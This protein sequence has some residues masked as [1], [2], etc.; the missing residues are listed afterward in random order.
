MKKILFA[1]LMLLTFTCMAHADD[2]DKNVSTFAELISH[3]ENNQDVTLTC[4]ITADNDAFKTYCNGYDKLVYSGIFD[5]QGHKLTGLS[6]SEKHK[7][8]IALFRAAKGATFKDFLMIDANIC[9]YD[10]V[11]VFCVDAESCTLDGI[12]VRGRIEANSNVGGV[13]SV[14]KNSTFTNCRFDYESSETVKEAL[15]G[16]Y[17]IGGI[18]GYSDNCTF[19][20]CKNH[21]AVNGN[22][23]VG[24]ICGYAL[25]SIITACL[26]SAYISSDGQNAGGICGLA[27][28]S[29]FLDCECTSSGHIY[30]DGTLYN[31]Y[32][33]GIVGSLNEDDKDRSEYSR[34]EGC[35]NRGYVESNGSGY[36]GGITGYTFSTNITRCCN[37]GD[38][39]FVGSF[40]YP[41]GGIVGKAKKTNISECYNQGIITGGTDAGGIAGVVTKYSSIKDCYNTGWVS[42]SGSSVGG[43]VSEIN[44]NSNV[45]RCL[46]VMTI[47]SVGKTCQ[48]YI[49]SKIYASCSLTDC[50]YLVDGDMP[51]DVTADDFTNGHI[52]YLLNGSTTPDE[53]TPW[54][55]TIGTD[56]VPVL[57]YTDEL[58]A[59]HSLVYVMPDCWNGVSGYCN[60]QR[61]PHSYDGNI[62]TICGYDKTGTKTISNITDL[63]QFA[64]NVSKN[65]C[66]NAVLAA[67][68]TL[69]ANSD[70]TTYGPIGAEATYD[71][72][73][74]QLTFPFTG[75]FDGQGHTIKFPV[76]E[77]ATPHNLFGAVKDATIK[78]LQ[79]TGIIQTEAPY[80]AAIV[81]YVC[82][83]ETNIERCYSNVFI[84]SD[85]KGDG[86]HS[87]FVAVNES[88]VLNFTNCEYSGTM[89]LKGLTKWCAGF[90][91]FN[92][93]GCTVNLTNCLMA[94]NIN[95]MVSGDDQT[96]T[97]VRHNSDSNVNLDNCYY[98]CS[99]G[100]AQGTKG[101]TG[102][103]TSGEM[104][105]LLNNKKSSNVVWVQE[106]GTDSYPQIFMSASQMSEN[107][108]VYCVH[109]CSNGIVYSNANVNDDN[110]VFTNGICKCGMVEGEKM[111]ET[112]TSA[113]EWGTLC[114]PVQICVSDCSD[115]EFYMPK[116]TSFWAADE[117]VNLVKYDGDIIP[118]GTPI[119]Y[120]KTGDGDITITG[121][122]NGYVDEDS[123]L[124]ASEPVDYTIDGGNWIFRGTYTPDNIQNDMEFKGYT[125]YYFSDGKL[126]LASQATPMA[127]NSAW[128]ISTKGVT[129]SASAVPLVTDDG[130]TGITTTDAAAATGTRKQ[131][132][133]G[134]II[135]VNPRGEIF[136]TAGSRVN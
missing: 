65:V 34:I 67:D 125:Y 94:G 81:N 104:T 24:G 100:I 61:T 31:A 135:I 36:V 85:I 22:G 50:Y 131:L 134:R 44:D 43:I 10:S 62:C 55:Q 79:L 133:D 60:E 39:K 12:V 130:T 20:N 78:N 42:A 86:S 89:N 93:T 116:Q 80:T 40:A 107:N 90:V 112:R 83:D 21:N 111:T 70:W 46:N 69:S 59:A 119:I 32:C 1:A 102:Q 103:L 127:A 114:L 106:I 4:D 6:L 49:N 101:T 29:Q 136:T 23:E 105:Y 28:D 87:G 18:A 92:K 14:C 74:T 72:D 15:I 5:G 7:N 126:C 96:A 8:K 113:A 16:E 71:A 63:C 128:L 30:C 88:K 76:T 13:C 109:S 124:Y 2:Y 27:N 77:S 17:T 41:G 53:A 9:G 129:S 19:N 35:I 68:I 122:G 82:G 64:Y 33:G 91:G 57:C 99:G 66:E 54:R 115:V 26:N 48:N 38:V 11:A 52:T 110:H 120:Y 73:G 121:Y 58:K 45:S 108:V 117:H 123:T 51:T 118:A 47:Y 132:R 95:N 84:N 56:G 97:F 3:I 25:R 75:T 37:S 98:T